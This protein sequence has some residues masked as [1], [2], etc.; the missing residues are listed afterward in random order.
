MNIPTVE[1]I[2]GRMAEMMIARDAGYPFDALVY[3]SLA[4][5]LKALCQGQA[6]SVARAA[7][8]YIDT[9]PDEVVAALPAM[10][11]FDRDWAENV[12]AGDID[13]DDERI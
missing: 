7:L 8:D 1:A 12:I 6:V 4:V 2:R 3:D 10:P 9:L 5:A 11:G 13:L